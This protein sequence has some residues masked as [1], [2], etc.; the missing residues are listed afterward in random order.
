MSR[1]LKKPSEVLTASAVAASEVRT[2]GEQQRLNE[3]VQREATKIASEAVL[4]S[5]QNI[6]LQ[7]I[8]LFFDVY[9]FRKKRLKRLCEQLQ[10]QKIELDKL[11]NDE[12]MAAIMIERMKNFG[13]DFTPTFRELLE[14]E[15]KR[16]KDKSDKEK[17]IR[18]AKN[19]F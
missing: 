18:K 17:A 11:Y 7:T 15:E 4:L 10:S 3:L 12:V 9:G 8:Y 5:T 13:I 16:F 19:N 6:F 1:L 2:K 14:N